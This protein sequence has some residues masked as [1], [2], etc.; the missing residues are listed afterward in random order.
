MKTLFGLLVNYYSYN[1]D[2]NN[3]PIDIEVYG[4]ESTLLEISKYTLFPGNFIIREC[5]EEEKWRYKASHTALY[6]RLPIIED[7][8]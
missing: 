7:R 8:V 1:I 4:D 6:A 2:E 5:N 3:I